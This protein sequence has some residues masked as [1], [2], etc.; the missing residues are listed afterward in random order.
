MRE[1]L[2]L[3]KHTLNLYKGDLDELRTLFP[4]AEPTVIVRD[5]VH[6]AVVAERSKQPKPQISG[7]EVKI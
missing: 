3:Q 6:A 7:V 4:N 2:D 1:H 5:L